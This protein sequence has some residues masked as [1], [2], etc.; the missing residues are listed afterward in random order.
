MA[1]TMVDKV[2]RIGAPNR[3][4]RVSCRPYSA[5]SWRYDVNLG[6]F[7]AVLD[8]CRKRPWVVGVAENPT[9]SLHLRDALAQHASD[10][11]DRSGVVVTC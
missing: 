1:K 11:A 4:A 9:R 7:P 6:M 8:W 10:S 5:E 2:L 3:P